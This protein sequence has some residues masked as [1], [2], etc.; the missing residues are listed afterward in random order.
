MVRWSSLARQVL[1]LARIA[2]GE[3]LT[4]AGVR[5][6]LGLHLT[7]GVA[8][9]IRDGH[10]EREE[11]A[12]VEALVRPGDRLMEVGT[13]L[14]LVATVAARRLGDASV[15]T[16]E[17]NP[18]I[19]AAARDTFA[20]NGVAP[21]L[22]HGLV[23]ARDGRADLFVPPDFWRASTRRFRRLTH[24][25]RVPMTSFTAACDAARPTI[26]VVDAEGAELELSACRG[27]EHARVVVLEVHPE[28]IGRDGVATVL[29][30]LAER[31][32]VVTRWCA[33]RRVAVLE[34]SAPRPQGEG[35]GT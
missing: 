23:G 31:G 34:R 1:L 5:L 18:R 6:R 10:Y 25:V 7:P 4:L 32:L 3:V 16:W 35:G 24:R 9:A 13:G 15:A 19:V 11:V 17:A 2:R 30:R 29:A 26:L 20:L 33:R 22:H 21:T 14:G 28:L 12:F 27:W 8:A